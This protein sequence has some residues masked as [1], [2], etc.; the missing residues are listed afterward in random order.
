MRAPPIDNCTR[1]VILER[2]TGIAMTYN[3]FDALFYSITFLVPGF[4]W[5]AVLSMLIPR[6]MRAIEVRML[7]FLTFSCL[8]YAIWSWLIYRVF[9]TQFHEDYLG[10]TCLLLFA[11]V[12]VS[13]V[14]LGLV[15]G[16]AAQSNW[17][18]H[19]LGRLGFRTIHPIP[20]AWDFHF[21]KLRPYWMT[22]TLI[23]RSR[24]HGLFGTNSFAGDAPKDLYVEAVFRINENGDWVPV[25]DSGGVFIKAEQI[26]AIEFRKLT[27]VNYEQ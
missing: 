13:P 22:V 16:K 1:G 12:F 9:R 25:V 20:A 2:N 18:A 21:G 6:R 14:A 3:T 23:D 10:W 5:S 26:A 7:E 11:I 24:V 17:A 15:F 4:V 19:F 8:N 27:E